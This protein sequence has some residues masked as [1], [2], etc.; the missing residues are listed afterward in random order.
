MGLMGRNEVLLRAQ[1]LFCIWLS[2][3]D[4]RALT[5]QKA[6]LSSLKPTCPWSGL[7][8][9]AQEDCCPW[10]HL[11]FMLGFSCVISGHF[12]L[13]SGSVCVGHG[14]L[15]SP[16]LPCASPHY[17]PTLSVMGRGGDTYLQMEFHPHCNLPICMYL[18][19][20][21]DIKERLLV[22]FEAYSYIL[23]NTNMDKD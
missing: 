10:K 11:L 23:I 6:D 17:P 18:T 15:C 22:D 1:P 19:N 13:Q 21:K 4:P 3:V 2:V 14:C 9:A 16:H 8:A 20:A 12:C 5:K 7:Q